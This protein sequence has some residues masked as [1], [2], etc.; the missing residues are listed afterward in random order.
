MSW[1]PEFGIESEFYYNGIPTGLYRKDKLFDNKLFCDRC[2]NDGLVKV[3]DYHNGKIIYHCTL[4]N[5][6]F[7]VTQIKPNK[8]KDTEFEWVN[9]HTYAL[10]DTSYETYKNKKK[11]YIKTGIVI[12]TTLLSCILGYC[13]GRHSK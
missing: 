7:E 1:K 5:T 2:G 3:T 8:K 13:I 6:E 4:C 9:K 12:V 10:Y 11:S